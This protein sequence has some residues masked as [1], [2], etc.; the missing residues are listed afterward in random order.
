M[1][2][3]QQLQDDSGTIAFPLRGQPR[4][5]SASATRRS[6]GLPG[7]DE[8]YS[9]IAIASIIGIRAGPEHAYRCTEVE[10]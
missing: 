7:Q 6:R 2:A 1:A 4:V 9:R 8:S 3:G 10:S 5:T